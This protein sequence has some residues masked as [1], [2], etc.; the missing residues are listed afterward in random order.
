[1]AG[2]SL[3]EMVKKLPED[4][5]VQ[6]IDYDDKV[7]V[8]QTT[9][10]DHARMHKGIACFDRGGGTDIITAL[11]VSLEG[12]LATPS[13]RRYLF[14]LTDAAIKQTGKDKIRFERLLDRLRDE[15]IFSM[16]IGLVDNPEFQK[17]AER[18]GGVAII[19]KNFADLQQTIADLL[20]RVSQPPEENKSAIELIWK[21]P[22]ENAPPQPVSGT[23]I[24]EL[25]QMPVSEKDIVEAR[26]SL[27]LRVTE[28]QPSADITGPAVASDSPKTASSK[29]LTTGSEN[30][31]SSKNTAMTEHPRLVIPADIK[32]QNTACS[33]HVSSIELFD[34]INGVS[35][36]KETVFAVLDIQLCNILPEQEVT[37]YPDGSSHPSRWIGRSDTEA[38]VI[39]AIPPYLVKD[40][41][42]HLFLRWN[43]QIVPVSPATW[44][45][46]NSL[47]PFHS[48][49]L[50]LMPGK[51]TAGRLVFLV[52]DKQGLTSGACDFYDTAY[53]HACMVLAGTPVDN[54]L[55]VT[56][57]PQKVVGKL[58]D[59]FFIS[60]EAVTDIP[61]PIAGV[62][63]GSHLLYRLLDMKLDSKVQ[64]L[65]DIKPSERMHLA[66]NTD[67]GPVRRPLSAAT[68][69]L[70]AGF[71][72]QAR[73]A[74]GSANYLRQAY[75]VPSQ[76][77]SMS[78]GVLYIDLKGEDVAINL[79]TTSGPTGPDKWDT[80]GNGLKVR[81]NSVEK[82]SNKAGMRGEYLFVDT[83]VS[84]IADGSATRLNKLLFLGRADLRAE[85]FKTGSRAIK[86]S[87]NKAKKKGMGNFS[88]TSESD[89]NAIR[90]YPDKNNNK[91]LFGANNDAV[92]PD[93]QQLRF[94]TA[95][96]L[97]RNGSYMLAAE[98]PK[99]ALEIPASA[100]ATI[101]EWLFAINDEVIPALP[102]SFEKALG[103]RL[104]QLLPEKKRAADAEKFVTADE[105]GAAAQQPENVHP[106]LLAPDNAFPASVKQKLSVTIEAEPIADNVAA[107]AG[108]IGSALSGKADSKRQF[109]LLSEELPAD[110]A[111]T[112]FEISYTSAGGDSKTKEMRVLLSGATLEVSGKESIDLKQWKPVKEIIRVSGSSYS[113][114][115]F[116]RDVSDCD[117]ASRI[118]S[119]AL[120]IPDIAESR[121]AELAEI[122][123]KTKPEAHPDHISI[124]RWYAHSRIARFISAQSRFEKNQSELLGISLN[125]EKR[126]RLMIITAGNSS[127][128]NS[129]FEARLDLLSV[130]PD[131]KGSEEACRAFRIANGM[132]LTDLEAGI[133]KGNGVF[134]FWGKNNLFLIA[135]SGKPKAAWLKFAASRGVS[136]NVISTIKNSKSVIM[137]PENPATVNDKPFWSWLEIDPKTYETI[138]V[139]ETGEHGTIAGEAIIQALIPDGAGLMLGFMKGI[140]T[141]VWGQCAFIIDGSSYEE[142]LAKTEALI[143]QLGEH[144]GNVGDSFNVPVGGD[145]ELDLLS[146]KLSLG[147]FSSDGTY[148]PWDGYKSFGSG[149]E[150]GAKYY[151][152]KARAAGSKN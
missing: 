147:G 25:Q 56:A 59:A 70:P 106:P 98:D 99:L 107:Q 135:P 26:D 81:I 14:F 110:I 123:Q 66:I 27:T 23:G 149:F 5:L 150:M 10:A 57:L 36:P 118:H 22:M 62:T 96:A 28:L 17:V 34:T 58:G 130:L 42:Q 146:G 86:P 133:M 9:T 108:K 46:D 117:L 54:P 88:D 32:A 124:W 82:H 61:A 87:E 71:Y 39:K 15:K 128:A 148:S 89:G 122:W 65:L 74:P 33:F 35:A 24:F 134:Q 102:D 152:E 84:D 141:A 48:Y 50:K 75:L 76:L 21:M 41:R 19:S 51:S 137:F 3:H 126:P 109:I 115:A 90:I 85:G 77:A 2:F 52:S 105:T 79:D 93:G 78:R 13:S 97:P 53:G 72:N 7:R 60:L 83:T 136:E 121:Q 132:F 40:I 125:R 67:L 143:G 119:I 111:K 114:P 30:E 4:C 12:L 129:T 20:G 31:I 49:S 94:I 131:I 95:F 145:A 45:L 8:N 44:L 92:V 47:L 18:S 43:D 37:I 142:A 63:A 101:P 11:K 1:M 144:L 116:T 112:P 103:S 113:F 104:K 68:A 120:G 69:L 64:A 6:I 29:V 140:E 55:K 73:L 139:L 80:E 16:W 100:A 151:I 91:L 127:G 38:K 138:G